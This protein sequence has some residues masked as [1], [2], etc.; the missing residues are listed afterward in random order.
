MI[1]RNENSFMKPYISHILQSF[2]FLRFSVNNYLNVIGN[3]AEN[4]KTSTQVV[5]ITFMMLLCCFYVAFT[6]LMKFDAF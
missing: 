1:Y 3:N 4:I 2:I 5:W 6:S